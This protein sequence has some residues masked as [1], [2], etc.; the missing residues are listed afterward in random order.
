MLA[1]SGVGHATLLAIFQT[2]IP[3]LLKP[4][5]KAYVAGQE[6]ADIVVAESWKGLPQHFPLQLLLGLHLCQF[7]QS[8]KVV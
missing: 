8:T 7:V 6:R 3:S 2:Q 1:N 4:K 5:E